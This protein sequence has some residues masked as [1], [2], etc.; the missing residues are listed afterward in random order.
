[1]AFFVLASLGLASE[2]EAAVGDDASAVAADQ[3]RFKASVRLTTV[4][5][6]QVHQLDTEMGLTIKEYVGASGKIFAISWSG[7]GRPE[8]RTILGDSRFDQ[9]LAARRAQ[10]RVRGPVRLELPGMVIAMGAYARTSWGHVYL[11]GLVPAGWSE[12]ALRGTP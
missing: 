12:Q 3:A 7:N 9:Y 8:L 6:C 5:G 4:D 1:M 10:R 2:G 11:P